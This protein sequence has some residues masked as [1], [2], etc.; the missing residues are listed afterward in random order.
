MMIPE[1]D[2]APMDPVAR[3][4]SVCDETR[5]I[6]SSNEAHAADLLMSAADLI[7]PA[8]M[9][10]ASD[11]ASRALDLAA[12]LSPLPSCN[13]SRQCRGAN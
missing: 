12:S 10:L 1:L 3:L 9:G 5:R 11:F 2:A 7:P 4:K 8:A 6:K 13:R